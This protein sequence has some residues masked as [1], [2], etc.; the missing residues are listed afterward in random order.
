MSTWRQLAV[1]LMDRYNSHHLLT[2]FL[3]MLVLSLMLLSLQ[4]LLLLPL[5]QPITQSFCFHF[6]ILYTG[7]LRWGHKLEECWWQIHQGDWKFNETFTARIL[8]H[9]H[10]ILRVALPYIKVSTMNYSAR[11]WLPLPWLLEDCQALH[12][13]HYHQQHSYQSIIAI[14]MICR[15]QSRRLRGL[16]SLRCTQRGLTGSWGCWST[17]SM[18]M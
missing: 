12:K 17:W 16:S 18:R 15:W 4:S 11:A 9:L 8:K 10:Y 5:I 3:L 2:K 1:V 6:P 14:A 7:L 13:P